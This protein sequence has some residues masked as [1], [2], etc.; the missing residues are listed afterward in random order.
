MEAI[1]KFYERNEWWLTWVWQLA[2]MNTVI[3]TIL[4]IYC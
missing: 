4:A 1:Y 3:R 2:A